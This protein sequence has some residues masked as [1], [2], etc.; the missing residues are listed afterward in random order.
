MRARSLRR[1]PLLTAGWEC[2]DTF[3][4][5]QQDYVLPTT[6]VYSVHQPVFVLRAPSVARLPADVAQVRASLSASVLSV[7]SV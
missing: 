7:A 2:V 6:M 5:L 3:G 4:L 1:L